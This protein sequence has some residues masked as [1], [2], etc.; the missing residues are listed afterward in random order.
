MIKKLLL[1][2]CLLAPL[3]VFATPLE[4]DYMEYSSDANAQAAYVTNGGASDAVDQECTGENTYYVIGQKSAVV[5]EEGQSFQLSGALT[6]SAVELRQYGTLGSP[7]GQIHIRIETSNGGTP[8]YPSGNL[9]D[10]NA[11]VSIDAPGDSTNFKATFATPFAL[12]AATTYFIL[13]YADAQSNNNAWYLSGI[14]TGGYGSGNRSYK[15]NGTWYNSATQDMYFKIYTQTA[16]VLTSYSESTIKTQGSYALKAVATTG[17]LN[18]TL[19]K[20]FASPLDLSGINT[21]K[22]DMRSTRTGANL[23]FGLHDTGGTTTEL[24]PTISSADTFETK[25][26]DLSGVSDANKNVIDTLTITIAN[27]DSATT[28]YVDNFVEKDYSGWVMIGG[29]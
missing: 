26:F 11:S 14:T 18:K 23:K 24:T 19:T 21:L 5:Y 13:V 8:A 12:S 27:A 3:Q 29:D 22:L 9:A 6:V 15:Y 7:T 17:A 10:A 4:I 25:T 2:I 16:G 28:W 20:T 1:T